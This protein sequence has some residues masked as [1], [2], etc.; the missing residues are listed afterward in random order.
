M[1]S[2][3]LVLSENVTP[4]TIIW[5]YLDIP[6][7]LNLLLNQHL[8]FRR[9]DKFQDKLEG[10]MPESAQQ[11]FKR[12]LEGMVSKEEAHLRTQKETERI[13]KY[14]LWA[15]ANCWSINTDE[16]YALWKIYLNGHKEGVAIK[17]T[18]EKLKDALVYDSELI[19]HGEDIVMKEVSYN[20]L[21]KGLNQEN[22]NTSKY[23]QYKYESELRIFFKNQRNF[24]NKENDIS[25]GYNDKEIKPI[26]VDVKTM[27]QEL[28]ISPF[29]QIWFKD[30]L[31]DLLNSRFPELEIKFSESKIIN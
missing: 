7:F 30:T 5:K 16:N 31:Q 29:A 24:Q 13:A 10:T 25:E 19:K 15:Y 2:I 27:I 1:N 14:K 23:V 22:V 11:D 20:N 9:F 21:G 26:K 18:V 8:I 12:F 28:Y 4:E 6:T 3:K 17:S